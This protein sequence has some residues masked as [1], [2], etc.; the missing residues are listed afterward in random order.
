MLVPICTLPVLFLHQSVLLKVESILLFHIYSQDNIRPQ[1]NL[2]WDLELIF[3]ALPCSHNHTGMFWL[4]SILTSWNLASSCF[5]SGLSNQA[6]LTQN[7][8]WFSS[9]CPSTCLLISLG[10]QHPNLVQRASYFWN[11][12]GATPH[13]SLTMCT[14]PWVQYFDSQMRV[15][16]WFTIFLDFQDPIQFFFF[17]C[18]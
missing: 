10:H 14:A 13:L 12:K 6:L 9:S 5:L 17:F 2:L 1:R 3:K 11:W 15:W 18:F 4:S 16:F 7:L 8:L